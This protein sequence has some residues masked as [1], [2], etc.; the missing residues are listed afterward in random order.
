MSPN[1]DFKMAQF[2]QGHL[3]KAGRSLP[4]REF[5]I[6]VKEIKIVKA[7]KLL[8][9]ILLHHVDKLPKNCSRSNYH[10][11]LGCLC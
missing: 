6:V 8:Y 9:Y 2:V 5:A 4:V 1:F 11:D 3:Y 10:A 7:I